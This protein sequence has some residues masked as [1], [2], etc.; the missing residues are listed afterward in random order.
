MRA[1]VILLGLGVGVSGLLSCGG[2]TCGSGTRESNGAC[3]PELTCNPGFAPVGGQC[4]AVLSCGP[5]T[6]AD[7]GVC[8]PVPPGKR[9]EIRIGAA[10]VPADGYSKI[11]VMVLGYD[12]TGA[13]LTGE[14]VSLG[15]DHPFQGSLTPNA[16]TLG[17]LGTQAWFVPCSSAQVSGCTGSATLTVAAAA[18][19]ATV[20][21]R[22][23]SFELVT[24]QGVGSPAPCEIGGNVLFFDGDPFDFIH[25]GTDTIQ[26]GSWNASVT[27]GEYLTINVYPAD[28]SQG[29]WWSTVFSSAALDQPLQ[30]QVYDGAERAAFAPPGHPGLDVYGDGRGCN[31]V[32]GRFQVFD[33]QISGDTVNAFT[34]TFEQACEGGSTKLRGCVHYTQ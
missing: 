32:A 19:P 18:S 27:N 2:K 28:S 12:A 4:V 14:P 9:Y 25:P 26:L 15:V 20:L 22:S 16:I 24:P 5:G 23:T 1:I 7:G 8:T 34:A 21:A 17:P 33:V 29:G 31:T 13:P 10:S 30:A 11:P 6:V 3:V